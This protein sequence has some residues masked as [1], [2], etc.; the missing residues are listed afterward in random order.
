MMLIAFVPSS[1]TAE[2]KRKPALASKDTSPPSTHKPREPK[3]GPRP[4][5]NPNLDSFEAVME[6]MEAE[7]T[8]QK[9]KT[10]TSVLKGKNKAPTSASAPAPAPTTSPTPQRDAKGKGKAKVS[11]APDVDIADD[12]I[13]IEAAMEAELKAALERGDLD[14]DEEGEG[15]MDYNLIKNFLESFKSQGGLSGPVSNL[16]GRLQGDWTLPRDE[17]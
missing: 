11:F 17:S 3:P 16:A 12:D 14:S 2:S 1:V 5:V 4:N 10:P 6:A 15:G 8:N 9:T 7:L 13:D